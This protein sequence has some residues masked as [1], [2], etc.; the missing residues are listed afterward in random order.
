MLFSIWAILLLAVV[1]GRK[2]KRLIDTGDGH[3]LWL[4]ESQVPKYRTKTLDF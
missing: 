2:E 1:E 3:A 4:R